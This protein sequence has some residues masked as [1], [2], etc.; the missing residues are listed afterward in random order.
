MSFNL[1]LG[2][3]IYP[4]GT[5][6]DGAQFISGYAF[7]S[8]DFIDA[9][10][11]VIKIKNIQDGIVTIADS[12]YVSPNT[13]KGLDRFKLKNG[14]VL[15]AMTGQGSVGRVGRLSCDG[16][17][18]PYLN[19][20]VGK[21]L[22]DEKKLNIDFLYYILSTKQ[23]QEVLFLSGS[24]SGQPNLSP[25]TI[26]SI[27]IPFAPY[28]IQC[29]IADILNSIDT[30]IILNRKINQILEQMA[31]ALFKSWFVDF[32]PVKAKIAVLEA[33]G[34]QEEAT[35][36]AMT[37]ISG[38]DADSLAFFEREYPEQ[39]AELKVTAELFPSAMQDS[40]LGI[41]PAGWTL[42]EIGK[43]I[44]L[45][46]GATPSTKISEYWY[47]GDVNWTTPKDMSNLKDKILIS[48]ERK[49]TKM[50]LLKI[51]S[52][53]LPVNTIL[54]SSRA[55]VGYLAISKIPVAINQGYIA[56]KCNYDLSPEFVLQ[57]CSSNMPEIINRSSGTTFAE[58]S[59]KNFSSI[60]IIKPDVKLI[61]IYSLRVKK[62]YELIEKNARQAIS[63]TQISNTLIPKLLSGDINLV[64]KN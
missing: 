46:G 40:E 41:I 24:G 49:I 44:D 23:Y 13:V 2:Y 16:G 27:E 30:R 8:K 11:P 50:G 61:D 36:A 12:Q 3:T 47:S 6:G 53:L 51:S 29:K 18:E 64:G 54:M 35:L 25:S 33:G 52:G 31:Q 20:R 55:P 38:K 7:K 28:D 26:K 15:I 4:V 37:A 62:L 59:K 34:S 21:F 14:D 22:A 56:M 45:V 10:C 5:I 1:P 39:Y 60:I 43:E 58:I 17:Y 48:T 42:S 19:Q 9:G 63:L 32:E 57:W